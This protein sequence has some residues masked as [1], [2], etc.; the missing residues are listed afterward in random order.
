MLSP[1]SIDDVDRSRNICQGLPNPATT[2]AP[3]N[4][5][6]LGSLI[7]WGFPE[8]ASLGPNDSLALSKAYK[9]VRESLGFKSCRHSAR[10]GGPQ[11][12]G[13]TKGG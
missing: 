2:A 9:Q 1:A 10:T 11:L 8:N 7:L 6:G 3:W 5:M 13:Q 4:Q 12:K